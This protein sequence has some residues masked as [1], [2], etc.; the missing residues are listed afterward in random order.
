MSDEPR[1]EILAAAS[2][3]FAAGGV[4]ATTMAEIARR[5][6]LQ[7][8]SLYY[9]F[10]SKEALLDALVTEAN[11]APLELVERIRSEGGAPAVQLYRLIRAD[12]AALS[13]LPYDLNELHRMAARDPRMFR[14]YWRERERLIAAVTE[15][16]AAGVA[17]GELRAI[18]PA[19]S[20]LTILSNDEATQHWLRG[21]L[22]R[23]SRRSRPSTVTAD[24][25]EAGRFLADLTL[26][27]LMTRPASLEQIRR[28]A[29]TLDDS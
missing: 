13:A 10:H 15:I 14:R 21:D 16:I 9:Y 25:T 17:S 26:R 20:T 18:D 1:R 27:G 19:L 24:P 3:L 8:S 2:R 28:R 4:G 22:K 6:G 23:A 5:S 11:R 29:R 7:Q 12:V